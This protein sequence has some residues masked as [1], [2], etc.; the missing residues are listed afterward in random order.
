MTGV[1]T[2]AL[3]I[4]N[5]LLRFPY[6][7]YLDIGP[8]LDDLFYD[9][10]GQA[11]SMTREEVEAAGLSGLYDARKLTSA[12]V[13]DYICKN[14]GV[15]NTGLGYQWLKDTYGEEN[16]DKLGT[17]VPAYDAWY[18]E[19]SDAEWQEYVF[20]YGWEYPDGSV[21]LDFTPSAARYLGAN[22]TK[23][24]VFDRGMYAL[25]QSADPFNLFMTYNRFGYQ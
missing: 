6:E 8:Y 4:Y 10:D 2:C 14:F 24:I 16:L 9:L 25:V 15:K 1:Q 18:S 23:T 20:E 17:Y 3:P 19:R 5:G 21:R 22:G 7:S 12:Y 11:A 13:A